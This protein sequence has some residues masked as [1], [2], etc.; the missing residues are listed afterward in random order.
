MIR[1]DYIGKRQTDSPIQIPL[2]L[3]DMRVL[4]SQPDDESRMADWG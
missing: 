2:N 4:E 3:P 1:H